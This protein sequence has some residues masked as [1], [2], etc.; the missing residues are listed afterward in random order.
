[1]VLSLEN[2]HGVPF[3]L[4]RQSIIPASDFTTVQVFSMFLLKHKL[5]FGMILSNA[6]DG[7]LR[8][9]P[10]GIQLLVTDFSFESFLFY[11]LPILR[12][13]DWSK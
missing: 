13:H 8:R 3:I 5:V 9:R 2:F 6:I 10:T 12:S 1:M 4:L 11:S 7:T